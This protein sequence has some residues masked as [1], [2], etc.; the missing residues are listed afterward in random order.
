MLGDR[1]KEARI[2]IGAT[3]DDFA[4]LLK[5]KRQTY[6]AYERNVSL[7]DVTSLVILAAYFGVSIATLLGEEIKAT[8]GEQP[9]SSEQEALLESCAE[10][11]TEDIKKVLEYVELL[12]LKHNS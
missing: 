11:P 3:Q 4:A 8:Q 12:K 2:K 7:P 1:L 10:L 6:S 5:I 9:L